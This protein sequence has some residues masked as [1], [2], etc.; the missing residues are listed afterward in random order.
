MP[1]NP[2]AN[3][4]GRPGRAG[5]LALRSLLATVLVLTILAAGHGLV[6]RWMGSQL[7]AGFDDWAA[8]RRAQGW[9][10][11]YGVPVRGGWPLA[12]TLAL[13]QFR[14]EGGAATLPGGLD[15]QAEA[16]LLQVALPRLDRL[17]VEAPGRTRLRLGPL[18]IPF[19][20]DQLR[21][22]LPL[23]RN[24]LP[25]EANVAAER[26]RLGTLAGTVE[27]RSADLTIATRLTATEGEPAV[28]LG[29]AATEVDLPAG[30]VAGTPAL[31]ALGRKIASLSLDL[32]LTGP[33]PPGRGPAA[34][35]EAW[36]DGGGTLEL[37][38]LDLAWGPATANATA[39]LTLDEALQPM[40]A[41]SLRL[42]GAPAVVDA[43]AAGGLL[44]PRAAMAAR[45]MARLLSKPPP[46]GGPPQ[47]EVP[48]TLEDRTLTL[49]RFPVGRLPLWGWPV[50][51]ALPDAAQD[52]SLPARD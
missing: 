10:I 39:T 45:G 12:A 11:T 29:I 20:V 31:A 18:E 3:P 52:P 37:R 25:R 8:V 33:V 34:K 26:L 42:T 14:L 32:A 4:Q 13:P 43:A 23:E 6:W 27:I 24:V 41:G 28:E 49:A 19:A 35:A 38:G 5:R 44:T 40:G 51:P 17:V 7:Q 9:R 47:L 22:T 15:W 36:R 21:A 16:L 50:P 30:L 1:A 48:L 46:E 2:F